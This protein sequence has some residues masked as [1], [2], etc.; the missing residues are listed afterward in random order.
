MMNDFPLPDEIMCSIFS[1][2][3]DT[4][5]LYASIV[6][7]HWKGLCEDLILRKPSSAGHSIAEVKEEYVRKVPWMQRHPKISLFYLP[8]LQDKG[9]ACISSTS[10]KIF[11]GIKSG[12]RVFNRTL[13]SNPHE[14]LNFLSERTQN[15]AFM[16]VVKCSSREILSMSSSKCLKIF[17]FTFN[18]LLFETHQ[19]SE[20]TCQRL[21][22]NKCFFGLGS[23]Q[24]SGYNGVLEVHFSSV[25]LIKRE[26]I[27][28]S[29]VTTMDYNGKYLV[30]GT[31]AKTVEIWDTDKLTQSGYVHTL[32]SH[33]EPILS[34]KWID[35]RQF[36][37]ASIDNIIK[38]W[39]FRYL[40]RPVM[41]RVIDKSIAGM[42]VSSSTI[43]LNTFDQL[44]MINAE[45]KVRT[46]ERF[47]PHAL[48][49]SLHIPDDNSC[50]Y[51]GMQDGSIYHLA[52]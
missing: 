11:T 28:S 26:Y 24:K 12:V 25:Q 34:V 48:I 4:H 46:I 52:Y 31:L 36:V 45:G 18:R 41:E 1:H 33:Q 2:L 10:D 21:F 8:S 3:E 19:L 6:C 22:E 17:D 20:I 47:H 15:I 27:H 42:A 40:D 32:L 43:I 9:I 14:R 37:S 49:S 23:A 5:L 50:L 7:S 29:P 30:T 35:S 38:I 44:Q 39:D 13:E 16:D 51:T